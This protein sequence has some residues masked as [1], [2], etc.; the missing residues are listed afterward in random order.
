M[1]IQFTI[2]NHRSIKE[3]A[4]ISF[5]ASKDKSLE[6][7]LI[8]PDEKR[9]LLPV[10]AIYGANAAGKSN[11]LH[12]LMTMKDMIVGFSSKLSKGQKLPWEPF[13]GNNRPTSFEIM[14]IYNQV[15]YVYGFS[16]D[17]KKIYTEYLY[18][19]PNGRE[20]LIFSRENGAYEFRENINEQMTLSNRTL[21]NKLYLVSSNDWNLPQ[22]ENAYKWFLEKL[23]G[24]S[25]LP[26][27]SSETVA[28]IVRSDESKAR[29]LKEMLLADLGISDVSIKTIA[30]KKDETV[31]TTTH[32]IIDEEGN[33]DHFQL[34]MDQ[35]SSGTQRFFSRIGGWLQALENGSLLV[36]DE[37]ERSMHPLLTRRLIEMVQD[38]S[39]NTSGAQLLFTTHDALLLDL[40]LMRRDQIWFA[41]K[42]DRSCATELYSLA[43]FSPRKGENVRKGY[44]QGRFGAIP[45]IGGDRA[46]QE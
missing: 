32:R 35:E 39:I 46:W 31:I 6:S 36:V 4:V 9:T 42:N 26:A 3:S 12:A 27:A 16:F 25:E 28:E 21:D 45:F 10:L 14:Y 13:A 5:A 30:G 17:A 15:R 44:L 23:T 24:I 19:W 43:S 34:L 7:C 37:I 2:E 11:V 41:E 20:A 8:H 29:I 38:S 40:N 1:L 33:I 18:H 22:T